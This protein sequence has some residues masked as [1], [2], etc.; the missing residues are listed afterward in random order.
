[1]ETRLRDLLAFTDQPK[2]YHLPAMRENTLLRESTEY[3]YVA[4]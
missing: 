1:M 4:Q 3:E 2:L